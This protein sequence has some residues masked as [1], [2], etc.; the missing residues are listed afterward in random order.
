MMLDLRFWRR[1]LIRLATIL[2]LWLM[3]TPLHAQAISGDEKKIANAMRAVGKTWENLFKKF[4]VVDCGRGFYS[5]DIVRPIAFSYDVKRTD[6]LLEPYRGVLHLRTELMTNSYGIHARAYRR[7]DGQMRCFK[8]PEEAL[9]FTKDEFL[10]NLHKYDIDGE[11]NIT[12]SAIILDTVNPDFKEMI[13]IMPK[14]IWKILLK[15]IPI[16]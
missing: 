14:D 16:E 10:S 13:L 6:K 1:T 8:T 7:D 9:S 3:I 5:A 12:E 2:L 4:Y 15:P 11:Y